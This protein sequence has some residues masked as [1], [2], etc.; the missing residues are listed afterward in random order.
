[1]N[2]TH[3]HYASVNPQI[4]LSL[5]WFGGWRLLELHCCCVWFLTDWSFSKITHHIQYEHTSA[6]TTLPFVLQY[7]H[8]SPI[9]TVLVCHILCVYCTEIHKC[10]QTHS[11]ATATRELSSGSDTSN[12]A[13]N[14]LLPPFSVSVR[15]FMS[16]HARVWLCVFFRLWHW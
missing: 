14:W 16:L 11:Q 1:M 2:N 7:I 8:V 3:K 12:C 4:Q 9:W 10:T 15:V 13:Q 5:K 6:H